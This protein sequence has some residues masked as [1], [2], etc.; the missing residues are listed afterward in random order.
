LVKLK[1]LIIIYTTTIFLIFTIPYSTVAAE[2][3]LKEAPKD[4]KTKT[5][6]VWSLSLKGGI[7]LNAGNT[8]SLL[9][10]GGLKFQLQSKL[11][12]YSTNF[13]SFYGVSK[14]T[15]TVNKGEWLNTLTMKIRKRLN[16]YGKASLEY[17]E[18]SDIGLRVNT[19]LGIQYIIKNTPKIIVKLASTING[20][21]TNA[22]DI[23][24]N[25]DSLR[26]NIDF[27]LE[28]EITSMVKYTVDTVLTFNVKDFFH[29]YRV[30]TRAS[31]SVSMSKVLALRIEMTDKYNNRPLGE[32]IKKNDFI[33]VT[34]LEV[35]L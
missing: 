18:F 23:V 21:F 5:L 32:A 29:D 15:Q 2:I 22:F 28:Q 33:L 30:E 11:F 10:N 17:D 20:E 35:F 16:L 8:E 14:S 6:K 34:S 24:D 13:N 25:I 7:T 26:S 19:G 4:P 1:R 9:V 3:E 12:Q 31:L 27:S